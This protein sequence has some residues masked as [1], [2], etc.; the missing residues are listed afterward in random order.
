MNKL[1]SRK[2]L[3]VIAHS[4]IL[5]ANNKLGLGLDETTIIGL[6]SGV[7]AYIAGQSLVDFNQK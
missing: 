3:V 6:A 2:L 7:V 5:L 1:F 4:V